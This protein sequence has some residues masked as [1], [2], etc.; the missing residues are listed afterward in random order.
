MNDM[1]RDEMMDALDYCP[2]TG[3]FTWK[4]KTN[5]KVVV[6]ARAGCINGRGYL[7][8]GIGGQVFKAH[9]LAW[10]F[11][12]G[13]WPVGFIDHVNG[14]TLDNRIANLRDASRTEN[15]QNQRRAHKDSRSGLLGAFMA[16][17]GTWYSSISVNGKRTRLGKFGNAEDAHAAYV[18]A[19]RAMH[20]TCS[21]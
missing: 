18:A 12:Y 9:R 16:K 19:K 8:I 3:V 17:S 21:I 7:Q 5:P 10:F 15:I 4:K 6:G 11:V 20:V 14:V 13:C 2:D 1:T